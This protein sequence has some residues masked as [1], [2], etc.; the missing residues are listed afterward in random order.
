[1]QTTDH[2]SVTR[3][4][5]VPLRYD[6]APPTGNPKRKRGWGEEKKLEKTDRKQEETRIGKN[7]TGDIKMENLTE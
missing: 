7:G 3:G 5:S 1:M 4:S 2:T 6:T